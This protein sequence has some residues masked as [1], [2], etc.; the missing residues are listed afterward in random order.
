MLET[1]RA[2]RGSA[3]VY[4]RYEDLLADWKAEVDRAGRTLDLPLLTDI[5]PERAA[6][7][8][9]FV[10]P[11]LHRPRVG[12]DELEVPEGV[13]E[14]CERVWGLFLRR[15]RRRSLRELDAALEEYRKL[16]GEAEAIAQPSVTAVRPRKK[17]AA[18]DAARQDR[19]PHPE[20]RP[21]PAPPPRRSLM[22]KISVVVPVYNVEE[23]LD[24][25]LS[26]LV[27][28]TA[29]D[30]EI[31]V[32]DDGS[33]DGSLAIAERY[34]R[35]TTGSGSSRGPTAAWAPR[36]TPASRRRRASTSPSWTPTT[37]CR[38]R[39]TSCCSTRWRRPA[40]TSPPATCTGS[41]A[42]GTTQA[43]FL[44]RVFGRDRPKT[45]VKRFR[46]LLS[47][48][49]VPNKLW[50]RSFWDEHGFRFPEGCSTRT[51]PS[52]SRPSSWRAAST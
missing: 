14:L 34:A 7:V 30:L 18:A 6:A 38:P 37:C 4:I 27:R 21:Q 35:A 36:A 29:R 23:Y 43:P 41:P 16:Y 52:S 46:E 25:C 45:H 39:P 1:E 28:Q 44:A 48:R 40:R 33:T 24:D 9:A 5:A 22:A 47:D 17:Q 31:I 3:R 50:R 15:S 2:T 13:R 49:I 51:S 32:V 11:S 20:A 26:S 42:T 8:D 19:P 10:D 12:W